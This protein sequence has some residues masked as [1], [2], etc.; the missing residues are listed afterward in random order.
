MSQ[1]KGAVILIVDD[2]PILR[3]ALRFE[4]EMEGAIVT[5]AGGGR[6][7]IQLVKE[8][9]FHLVLSDVRMADGDGIELLDSIK[10]LNHMTPVVMLITGFSDLTSEQAYEKGCA[11]FIAKPF[12][13]EDLVRL[14]SRALKTHQHQWSEKLERVNYSK[15]VTINCASFEK[16]IESKIL[17]VSKGGMF[18][19]SS[20]PFPEI[21][22]ALNFKFTWE[23]AQWSPLEGEGMVRW[24]RKSEQNGNPTGYGV[25][26]Y[27]L[28]EST[29][30][31]LTKIIEQ[32][33]N[34]IPFIPAA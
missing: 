20:G 30:S 1:L 19:A 9:S 10:K 22:T 18:V 16:A 7:A 27:N 6:E 3:G 25:E 5:E 29:I 26:F 32:L 23:D 11:G 13:P 33:K 8:K 21:G 15:E 34:K 31:N 28:N 12:D 2:E 24:V 4:L 17:N 14:V